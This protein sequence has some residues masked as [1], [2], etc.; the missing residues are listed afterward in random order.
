M[1][2]GLNFFLDEIDKTPAT[3]GAWVD[4]DVSANGVPVGATGVILRLHNT[5]ATSYQSLAVRKNGSTDDRTQ[6]VDASRH[7]GVMVGI[8][9]NRVFEAKIYATT[10]KVFLIGYTTD[11]TDFLT[12]SLDK[13]PAAGSW[14]DVDVSANIPADAVGV[15]VQLVNTNASSNRTGG[16]R[17]NGSTDTFPYGRVWPV[18]NHQ[19]QV[20]GVDANRIFEAY[21]D[22][23]EVKVWL[24]GYFK[25]PVSFE[26]NAVSYALGSTSVWTDIAVTGGAA[27]ANA[28][29]A[30]WLIKETTS[31]IYQDSG[32]RKNGSASESYGRQPETSCLAFF[33]GLDASRV[34][35]GKISDLSVDHYVIGYAKPVAAGGLPLQVLV[36]VVGF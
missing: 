4:V 21:I 5:S 35:E 29:G 25:A 27:P 19:Y 15:I 26:D 11:G 34:A 6:N 10:F 30:M 24:I 13:T 20:C 12:N 33:C 14:L 7:I 9:A 17:K 31:G 36:N 1:P 8:D 22:N 3:T 28:D 23:V 16:V 18:N 2:S 32:V